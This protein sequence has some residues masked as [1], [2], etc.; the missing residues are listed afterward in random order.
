MESGSTRGKAA[1]TTVGD[2]STSALLGTQ[3]AAA[4]A[5]S[6]ALTSSYAQLDEV[7][8]GEQ[9]ANMRNSAEKVVQAAL[10]PR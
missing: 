7:V 8:V 4:A 1:Q 6:C 10:Y 2:S 3:V 5:A 9:T